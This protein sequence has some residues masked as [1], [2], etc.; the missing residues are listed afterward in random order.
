MKDLDLRVIRKL[1]LGGKNN[2]RQS[3]EINLPDFGSKSCALCHVVQCA[4]FCTGSL[5]V[6]REAKRLGFSSSHSFSPVNGM[7]RSPCAHV[8]D[9]LTALLSGLEHIPVSSRDRR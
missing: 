6:G 2:E 9:E 3:H 4:I 1:T 7:S 8:L 5:P